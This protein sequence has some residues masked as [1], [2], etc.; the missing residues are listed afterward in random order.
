MLLTEFMAPRTTVTAEVYFE[1]LNK[2]RRSIQN[3]RRWMLTRSFVLP[4]WFHDVG[5]LQPSH[6]L[7]RATIRPHLSGHVLILNA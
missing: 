3:K 6:I 5:K 4:G 2:L 1:K 7:D